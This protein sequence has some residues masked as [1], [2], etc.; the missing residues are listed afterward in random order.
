MTASGAAAVLAGIEAAELTLP[1]LLRLR[2]R[3]LGDKPLLRVGA[4]TRS[5]RQTCEIAARMAAALAAR[6]VGPGDRVAALCGNRIELMDLILGCGWLGATVVPLN[7]ALRGASLWQVLDAVRAPFVLAEPDL[8]VRLAEA[9]RP[10]GL[11]AAWLPGEVPSG[12][13]RVWQSAPRPEEHA[14]RPAAVVAPGDTLA[15]L[16]T[17]GT[18][19]TPL[20]VCGP[21]AQFAWWGINV[22][23]TL[24][25]S[26]DDVLYTCLPLFH[27][28]ALNAFAQALVAGATYVLGPRFSASAFWDQLGQAGATVTYLL[29]AMPGILMSRAPGPA[30][31]GHSCR[32]ALSPAT[33]AHQQAA[34]RERFGIVLVDG[35]GTTETSLVI[36]APPDEQR[37]G[38]LGRVIDGFEAMVADDDGGPVPDGTPG[39]LVVRSQHRYAFATGYWQMARRTADAWR[40]EWFHTGDRVVREPSGWFRFVDRIKDVI[41]RRGEN[42]S[43][44]QV[45]EV[46]CVHPD[47]AAAAAFAVPAEFAEDE[48]MVAVVT[49]PGSTVGPTDLLCHCEQQLPYFAV[50]RYVDLVDRLPVTETGKITKT[51]LRDRGITPA[52]W[53]RVAAGYRLHRDS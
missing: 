35:F 37:P 38:Y 4:V 46:L 39:E 15:I 28:N 45:E 9:G 23:R 8:A 49:R 26:Q 34:F 29:G 10:T 1:G 40:G 21:H 19:G 50:P 32:L 3:E 27:T 36:G 17:S 12:W 53:D 20:G 42:I 33:P 48:V 5:Y 41:R 30:D 16:F 2:A 13:S 47:V 22:T 43:S 25:I 11:R 14:P 31:R 7:T 24:R 6:G 18:T 44:R 51:P 52:T